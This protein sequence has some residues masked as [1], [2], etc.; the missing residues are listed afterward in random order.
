MLFVR[1]G[2]KCVM[3]YSSIIFS[4]VQRLFSGRYD[5]MSYIGLPFLSFGV[6]LS[7]L[8][9]AG[10]F[11]S[12][13]I[14]FIRCVISGA[15]VF[16]VFLSIFMDMLSC[17]TEFLLFAFLIMSVIALVVG[18]GISSV[19]FD[20]GYIFFIISIGVTVIFGIFSLRFLI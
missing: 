20:L 11:C 8:N 2:Y 9:M 17:P 12:S 14:C 19:T 18:I 15:I 5:P 6:I 1:K 7:I 16:V 3:K 13:I 4:I 10:N